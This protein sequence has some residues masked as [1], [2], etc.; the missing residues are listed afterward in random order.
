ME[1]LSLLFGGGGRSWLEAALLVCL[2]WAALIRPERIRS[3]GEFRA[4]AILLGI[5]IIAPILIQLL[6]I[7][8]PLTP[9][10]R[11]PAG[12]RTLEM[13]MYSMAIP[14]LLT[15]TAV[16]LGLD[17]VI[18]RSTGPRRVDGVEQGTS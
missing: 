13:S 8:Q 2:F 15:M 18:P 11:T 4:A 6:V 7:G 10:A 3:L 1:W 9:G 16:L 12:S 14:P 17:S 5:S